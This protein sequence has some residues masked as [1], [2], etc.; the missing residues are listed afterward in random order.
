[1]QL[2]ESIESVREQFRADSDPFPT[3][4]QS[5]ESLRVKYMGRKGLVAGLFAGMKN[6]EDKDR[7][8]ALDMF[9]HYSKSWMR[10]NPFLWM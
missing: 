3:D 1:M 7:P 9:I 6:I 4:T 10:L 2:K 8:L 5:V